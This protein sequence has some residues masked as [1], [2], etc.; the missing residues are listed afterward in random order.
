MNQETGRVTGGHYGAIDGLKAFS[1]IGIVLMH[2]RENTAYS[3]DG[4][5]YNRL[6]P[7][8]TNLVF[9]FMTISAFGMCCGY[10]ERVIH[11]NIA[12]GEFY[13]K[14]YRKIW[15][16]FALLCI[17]DL[18]ISPSINA[19]YETFANLTLCFGLLPNAKISV[20]GVGWFLGVVFV[21]YLLFPFFCW[22]LQ[23]KRRAW[24]SFGVMLMF[25]RIC[26][27]Y[28]FD[29]SHVIDGFSFRSNFIYCAVF[30]MAGGMIFLYKDKLGQWACK[31]R[32]LVLILCVLAA[33]GYYT[34]GGKVL[35][36]LMLFSMMLI[37]TLHSI[38]GT[39]QRFGK[40]ILENCITK[41]ISGISMEIYLCHMVV[42]R[43]IE[44][45]G[46]MHMFLQDILNYVV[47]SC[48]VITGAVI[49]SVSVKKVL[50]VASKMAGK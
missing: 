26:T 19:L 17:L 48:G 23:D 46:I 21:F 3:I 31:Y 15:P 14:R 44:K 32:W 12:F 5:I 10:Y 16:Y 22:L 24:F 49:F 30:F 8:F 47:V 2:V 29:E 4:F 35:S 18:L 28:F 37:Y 41:F 38:G 6:I 25:N 9:L 40:G 45:V 11:N 1:S 33:I 50:K 36:I 34:I 20:I 13:S 7:S 39:E 43:V 42:F 27:K